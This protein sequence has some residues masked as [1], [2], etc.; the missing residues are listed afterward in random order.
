MHPE[1]HGK[2]TEGGSG[3]EVSEMKEESYLCLSHRFTTSGKTSNSRIGLAF[4]FVMCPASFSVA[5]GTCL[6]N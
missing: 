3:W 2:E 1:K 6:P 5:S 4:A